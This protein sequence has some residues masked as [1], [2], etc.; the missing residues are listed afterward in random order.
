MK[1]C[2]R[3]AHGESGFTLI[4]I[5]IVVLIIGVLLAIAMPNFVKARETARAKNCLANLKEISAAKEQWVMDFRKNAD[6]TPSKDNLTAEGAESGKYL[7]K[8]P[9]C[10]GGGDYT[11]DSIGNPPTCTIEGHTL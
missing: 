4:E 11:I 8:W 10:P 7:K 5:M 9:S 6:D 2:K 1:R 3:N